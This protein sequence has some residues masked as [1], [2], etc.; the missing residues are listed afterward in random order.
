[1]TVQGDSGW[2]RVGLCVLVLPVWK[3][4]IMGRTATYGCVSVILIKDAT[5]RAGGCSP[6]Y[7]HNQVIEL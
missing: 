3:E 5:Y 2:V 1:M 7:R 4:V 6:Q